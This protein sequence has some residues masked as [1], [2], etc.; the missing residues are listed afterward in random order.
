A[1]LAPRRRSRRPA[2]TAGPRSPGLDAVQEA[3]VGAEGPLRRGREAV[4]VPIARQRR[5]Q[6]SRLGGV[7]G[8]PG[9]VDAEVVRRRPVLEAVALDE[10]GALDAGDG[11]LGALDRVEAGEP[12]ERVLAG[13]PLGDAGRRLRRRRLGAGAGRR[14][15]PVPK[16]DVVALLRR[17]PGRRLVAWQRP[18]QG[19]ARLGDRDDGVAVLG[20]VA[21]QLAA[22]ELAARPALVEGVA[23]HVPAIA[24][25]L[26]PLPDA[27]AHQ[28]L[29]VQP[30]EAGSIT[31]ARPAP[32]S[33][34]R[35][36]PPAWRGWAGRPPPSSGSAPVGRSW[37][38]S[39]TSPSSTA[40][41][42]SPTSSPG[43]SATPRTGSRC[44]AS[45][46]RAGPS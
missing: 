15:E 35:P 39:S 33:P 46:P 3:P 30:G 31:C 19:L 11:G 17:V 40:C 38:T 23:Q 24:R 29:L 25:A 36:F 26:D 41:G 32:T 20:R 14:G 21:R 44:W 4:G 45:T 12:V 10:P 42:P 8:V 43:T 1:R 22:R 7:L 16:R 28:A 13:R 2:R 37:C 27:S 34:F 6:R 9:G 5:D 18:R